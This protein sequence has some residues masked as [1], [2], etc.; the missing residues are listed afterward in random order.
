MIEGSQFPRGMQTVVV[1]GNGGQ[2]FGLAFFESRKAFERM[3]DQTRSAPPRRAY[4]VTFGPI[5]DLPFADADAWE[6]L[7]L[8]VAGPQAY[9]Q[10]ADLRSD[11]S[12]RRLDAKELASVEALLRALAQTTEDELDSGSWQQSVQ[13][14]RGPMTLKVTLPLLIEDEQDRPLRPRLGVM[15]R[16]AE[17][18][19]ARLA[20]FLEGRSFES[21]DEANAALEAAREDGLFEQP[22]EVAAGRSLTPL[23]QAQELVYDAMEATGR[24][25]IKLAR[26]ALALSEDCADASVILGEASSNPEAALDWYQRAIDAGARALGPDHFAAL[27]GQFW[28]H[29]E[30]RPY[31]RARLAFAQTLRE[32]GRDDEA[33]DHY[34]ELLRLNP[35]DNQGV[36][37]LLLPALLEDGRDDEADRLLDE[38]DGDIQAT[39]PYARTL[40]VFRA[41]GDSA[42]ARSTLTRAVRV[43]PHVAKYLL[44]PETM[45]FDAPSH[46]ALGSKDEAAYAA[47]GLQAAFDDTPGA[48]A[49]LRVSAAHAGGRGS[50]RTSV[51]RSR[52]R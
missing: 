33:I 34:R 27:V 25:K 43:N 23:E 17:R 8:S 9:P 24:L 21:L 47:E 31:M 38:Y 45:P 13:T 1:L 18:T 14:F 36:R 40:R 26:R 42:R 22:V 28:G 52:R 12:V 4:G 37:Y 46:F 7:A 10:A 51:K 15:P 50:P 19:N 44:D 39:W 29:L 2:Q 16:I 30:T 32:L 3:F 11:G 5:D 48:L 41:E 35:N 49:W 20:R 6:D